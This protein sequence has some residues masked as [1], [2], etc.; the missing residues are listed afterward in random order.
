MEAFRKIFRRGWCTL[1]WPLAL[2]VLLAVPG[3]G[4]AAR[5]SSSTTTAPS[6]TSTVTAAALSS[7]INVAAS[8]TSSGITTSALTAT[9]CTV[10]HG[11]NVVALHHQTSY[12]TSGQC[13]FCH[14]GIT[15]TG[16]CAGCHN[17][18]LT[19]NNHHV[20]TPGTPLNCASCHTNTVDLAN[21]LACHAGKVRGAHHNL[22]ASGTLCKTCH[23]SMV[24]VQV[25]PATAR[26]LSCAS[27]HTNQ[28]DIQKRHHTV[29]QSSDI[30]CTTCHTQMPSSASGDC[31]ACHTS[32]KLRVPAVHAKHHNSGLACLECH[33]Y[34]RATYTMDMPDSAKC[35]SCH[36]ARGMPPIAALHH[37]TPPYAAGNCALCH[38]GALNGNMDCATCHY[39]SAGS[40]T[41]APRHHAT[42]AAQMGQCVSCHTGTEPTQIVCSSCHTTNKHHQRPEALAGN[43]TFCHS[44][45]Q[46]NGGSCKACHTTPIPQLHHGAPLAS[47]GGNC[48][49]CHQSASD[50]KDCANCHQASPH[51][52][53]TYSLTGDCAHCHKAPSTATERPKQAGCRQCHGQYMHNKGGPI[54]DYRACAAC[55]VTTPFHAAPGRPLGYN[56]LKPAGSNYPT[57]KGTFSLFWN[58]YTRG[59]QEEI[60]ENVS[61]NGEDMNDEGGRKWSKPTIAFTL[62]PITNNGKTYQVPAFADLADGGGTTPPPVVNANLALNK[63]ASASRQESGYD[64]SRAFDGSASSRWWARSTSTQWLRVDLG[65]TT[66]VSKVTINWHSYYA[67][68]YSVQVSTNGSTWTTVKLVSSASGGT[69]TQTFTARDARY[70]RINCTRAASYNGY[71]INELEV[72][73]Q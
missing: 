2:M 30:A 72:Y 61:P 27:C 11:A 41:L 29:A 35:A 31:R 73:A 9:D 51:H 17:F 5:T 8:A 24:A 34:D 38:S 50:P 36:T 60:V 67:R 26:N 13:T 49:V 70:V 18:T 47:V 53:T 10:C 6:T 15:T 4:L 65:T 25:G 20:A 64:A 66:S 56:W 62:K 32:A 39:A 68:E 71:S 44:G 57:G 28:V 43:C 54:Q 21:C 16:T 59:G 23:T 48:A 12:Y 42:Q 22:A 45:I 19:N 33:F 52:T 14:T 69:V 37:A 1:L 58:Q 46:L 63:T 40:A 3:N 7:A 55:H